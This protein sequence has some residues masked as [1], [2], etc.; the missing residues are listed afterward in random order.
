[1]KKQVKEGGDISYMYTQQRAQT[2]ICKEIPQIHNKKKQKMREI[3]T[4]VNRCFTNMD[5]QI[6]NKHIEAI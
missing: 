4:W 3:W 1:M 2:K 6:A 5:I